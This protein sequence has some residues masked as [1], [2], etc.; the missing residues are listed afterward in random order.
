MVNVFFLLWTTPATKEEAQAFIS[1]QNPG[2]Y[3]RS[4][5]PEENEERML[6]LQDDLQRIGIPPEKIR[7]SQF[8]DTKSGYTEVSFYVEDIELEDALALGER[9]GQAE[10]L[11]DEGLVDV[12]SM[13]LKSPVRDIKTGDEALQQDAYSVI[14]GLGP[15]S[16]LFEEE[17]DIEK[18]PTSRETVK[19]QFY[20]LADEVGDDILQS[21]AGG[22]YSD[23][24]RDA[25]LECVTNAKQAVLNDN[26]E[27]ASAWIHKMFSLL[28]APEGSNTPEA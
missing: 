14:G 15:V 4:L 18:Q 11:T 12:A 7:I 20:Q 19:Q 3:Q 21:P 23:V 13:Q 2:G 27:G 5:T 24:E 6:Q 9:Y 8:Y 16:Y 28:G 1:A 10:I 25:L 22:R 17:L 26:P